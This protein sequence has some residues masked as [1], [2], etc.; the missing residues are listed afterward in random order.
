VAEA[1]DR[2]CGRGEEGGVR[3]AAPQR[4]GG[5]RDR[6][7]GCRGARVRLLRRPVPRPLAAGRSAAR[8]APSRGLR[9]SAAASSAA[10]ESR[11]AL[12]GAVQRPPRSVWRRPWGPARARRDR[13]QRRR[14]R[15]PRGPSPP[16]IRTCR[17]RSGRS[18]AS[19]RAASAR[20]CGREPRARRGRRGPEGG[21]AAGRAQWT[22]TTRSKRGWAPASTRRAAS[23]SGRL[24]PA[25][26]RPRPPRFRRAN[27]R[28]DDRV[29][30]RA[31]GGVREHDLREGGRSRRRRGRG[32]ARRI[33]RD[34]GRRGAPGAV[35]LARGDVE[36]E[37]A[38][39]RAAR[40]RSTCDFRSRCRR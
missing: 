19:R 31:G 23:V 29:Q 11:A 7:P 24:L 27:A 33:G 36:V 3:R 37:V 38:N 30:P 14:A 18:P 32:H 35:T 17:S 12:V 9:L 40:R 16:W 8:A 15:P 13:L 20:R 2:P 4:H 25:G 6:E 5:H 10:G 39:P 26:E 22:T 21:R 34:L 28:V 1:R